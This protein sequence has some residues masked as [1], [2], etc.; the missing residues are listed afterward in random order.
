VPRIDLAVILFT[1]FAAGFIGYSGYQE[2]RSSK[3][4]VVALSLLHSGVHF[5]A[6]LILTCVFIRLDSH[7]W[8][9][10]T[11]GPWWSWLLEFSIPMIF[12]GGLLAGLIFGANLFF[13]CRFA[14][15]SHNDAFSAMRLNSFRHFLRI[16]IIGDQFMVYPIGIDRIPARNEWIENPQATSDPTASYFG[17]PEWFE[18]KLI[19][20]PIIVS[21]SQTAQT[22]LVKKPS[23]LPRN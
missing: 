16:K 7:L 20:P 11:A 3:F 6:V 17:P 15:L 1:V 22:V 13:T 12:G 8:S 2:S 18:A 19:E 23:E 9:L 5:L 21:G 10:K 14:D 4:R